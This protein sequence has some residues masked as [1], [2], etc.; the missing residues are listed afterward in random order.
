MV[1]RGR[2][3]ARG[4]WRKKRIISKTRT[5]ATLIPLATIPVSL[6]GAFTFLYVFH[7]SINTITLLAMV[8]AIGLVVDDAIVV[9]ENIH[10]HIEEG[11]KPLDAA[12]KGAR[13]VGFAVIAMTLTLASV[14]AP[15]AF[16]QGLTGKLFAEFAVS[17]AG[18]VLISG[19]V[20]L[21]LS[22]MMCSK[23]LRPKE[24]EKK[25]WLSTHIEN[26][27]HTVEV[28][29]QRTLHKALSFPKV[30]S[31]ILIL[32]LAGGIFLF[33]KLPSELAPQEDQGI[34]FGAVAGAEG[35]TFESMIPYLLKLED[36][37]EAV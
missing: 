34:I 28:S 3:V 8:L 25:N 16:V 29:Y 21:T 30:L 12:F 37:F 24:L 10:R 22:P 27:L 17:L 15:I 19:L 11:L 1:A 31:G 6:I 26:F 13:E 4:E 5:I 2:R 36:L 33:Y 7:C 23:L 35:A 32:V 18:A 9:L 14:Y 20:A